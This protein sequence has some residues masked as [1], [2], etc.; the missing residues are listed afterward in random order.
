MEKPMATAAKKLSLRER[1][2]IRLRA[3]LL[4]AV[5]DLFLDEDPNSL[6][7][8]AIAR[9]AGCSKAT[10]Y[11]YFP[12]GLNEMLCAIY[13]EISDEVNVEAMRLHDMATSTHGRIMGLAQALLQ[14]STRPRRGKF[15]AQLNP[16]L[17]P[18]LQPVLGRA[19]RQYCE[20]I[21]LDLASET[22][23]DTKASAT[24]LIG[25]LREASV[26]V[27]RNPELKDE[28]IAAFSALVKGLISG[29]RQ[30]QLRAANK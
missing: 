19:S 8:E 28:L 21:A 6:N 23:A 27:A 3:E 16:A 24:L 25:A 18:A 17:V 9:N 4:E 5:L 7:V 20:V 26:R 10:V 2:K 29:L 22:G 13:E 15:Y 30:E 14:T 11:A 12:N 1:N